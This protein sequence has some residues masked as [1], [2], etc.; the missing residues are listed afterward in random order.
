MRYYVVLMSYYTVILSTHT[1]ILNNHTVILELF[2]CHPEQ[3]YCHPE[4]VEG[5]PV[6]IFEYQFV[7]TVVY[8]RSVL[9]G[10]LRQ[11][12]DDSKIAQCTFLRRVDPRFKLTTIFLY[13][14]VMLNCPR[15]N[16]RFHGIAA[17]SFCS[18]SLILAT[19]VLISLCT[20]FSLI[21]FS[22]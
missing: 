12:Q 14:G 2:Y 4:P 16:I 10:A 3:F 20:S 7:N 13:I 6:I 11:A 21:N 15:K 22:K 18:S 8:M 19:G 5:R 9:P 1:V 17:I